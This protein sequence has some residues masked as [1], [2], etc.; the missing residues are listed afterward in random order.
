EALEKWPTE[1]IIAKFSLLNALAIG[2]TEDRESFKSALELVTIAFQNTE[3][4][5][6]AQDI[7]DLLNGKK[8]GKAEVNL[9]EKSSMDDEKA[10][11]EE[12]IKQKNLT[13]NNGINS[14]DDA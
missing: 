14:P 3:E 10:K 12:R 7:L 4:A 11:E 13:E 1:F 8:G 2:A 9:N 5:K 6:K